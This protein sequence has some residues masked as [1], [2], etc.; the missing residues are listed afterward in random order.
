MNSTLLPPPPPPPTKARHPRRS[1]RS[2]ATKLSSPTSSPLPS[3]K[4]NFDEVDEEDSFFAGFSE[5]LKFRDDDS[6]ASWTDLGN[7]NPFRAAAPAPAPPPP[8]APTSSADAPT[9]GAPTYQLASALESNDPLEKRSDDQVSEAVVSEASTTVGSNLLAGKLLANMN[10]S[11]ND[12]DDNVMSSDQP[13]SLAHANHLSKTVATPANGNAKFATPENNSEKVTAHAHAPVRKYSRARGKFKER[14]QRRSISQIREKDSKSTDEVDRHD[15]VQAEKEAQV[16]VPAPVR[17]GSRDK[18]KEEPQ[19]RTISHDIK[20]DRNSNDKNN[21]LDKL[22]EGKQVH[23]PAPVRNWSRGKV[24][25]ELQRRSIANVREKGTKSN[26]G[27]NRQVKVEEEAQVHSD[28]DGNMKEDSRLGRSHSRDSKTEEEVIPFLFPNT[29]NNAAQD[30][31]TFCDETSLE[32]NSLTYADNATLYTEDDSRTFVTPTPTPSSHRS[33]YSRRGSGRLLCG[34]EDS[35]RMADTMESLKGAISDIN[36]SMMQIISPIAN[37]RCFV[38]NVVNDDDNYDDDETDEDE[39]YDDETYDD[40]TYDDYV[41]PSRRRSQQ[42][43]KQRSKSISVRRDRESS[44][45]R[46]SRRGKSCDPPRRV[47]RMDS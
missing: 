19:R 33:R 5:S 36:R 9:A 32:T 40:A 28:E 26:V 46:R 23:A 17:N 29:N 45:T 15:Q 42:H 12:N 8:P 24:R 2:V 18:V 47:T 39:T 20:N 11:P 3:K 41:R 43:V 37:A 34:C 27:D 35:G 14:M 30:V 7:A 31:S 44:T 21:R 16:P 1:P 10:S 38:D 25:E 4:L 13:V 6:W 22:E